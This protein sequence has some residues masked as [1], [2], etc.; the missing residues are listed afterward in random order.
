MTNGHLPTKLGW[1]AYRLNLWPGVCYSLA[2]LA[3]P[4]E[5]ASRVLAHHFF[6]LLPFLGVNR[7]IKREWRTIYRA[8]GGVGLFSAAIKHTIAMINMFIQHYGAGTMLAKKFTASLEA[9]QLEIGCVGCQLKESYD[10]FHI[11]AMA[12][13]VKSFWECLQFYGFE[14]HADYPCLDYLGVMIGC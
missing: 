10:R 6:C 14:I 13:W 9:L 5:V 12:C 4:L 7:N 11:L 8:F 3:V 1:V 2:T